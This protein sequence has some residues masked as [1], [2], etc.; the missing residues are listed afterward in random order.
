MIAG[1]AEQSGMRPETI[2]EREQKLSSR[3]LHSLYMQNYEFA[4]G[5]KEEQQRILDAE[6][7]VIGQIA[8]R[9]SCIMIGRLGCFFPEREKKLP[10]CLPVWR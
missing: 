1:I 10:E 6:K 4:P 7:A 3:F 2:E 8:D 5:E 9:Q